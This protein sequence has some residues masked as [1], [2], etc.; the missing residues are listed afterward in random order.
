VATTPL[1]ESKMSAIGPQDTPQPESKT[2]VRRRLDDA[3]TTLKHE[4]RTFAH[5]AQDRVRAEAQRGTQA[6][7]RT[8]GDFANAVRRAGDELGQAD[9]SPASRLVLKAADGLE[10]F[11]RSLADK[12]PGDLLNA[13]RDFGRRHPAAFIGGA[14]LAGLALGRFARSS[15]RSNAADMETPS[16]LLSHEGVPDPVPS[17]DAADDMGPSLAET[18]GL[19]ADAAAIPDGPLLDEPTPGA[20]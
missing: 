20:R 13:V 6:A 7:G 12:D 19:G 3:G 18:D 10:T 9:Q 16:D 4:A 15:D 14:V 8:L 17:A 5:V 2:A 11:S 1:A